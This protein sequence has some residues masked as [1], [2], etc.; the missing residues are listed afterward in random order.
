MLGLVARNCRIAALVRLLQRRSFVLPVP[1]QAILSGAMPSTFCGQKR[2]LLPADHILPDHY[3]QVRRSLLQQRSL[4]HKKRRS[5]IGPHAGLFFENFDTMYIQ[6]HEMVLI[7]KG[8]E[9][10]FAD[11]CEAY[12]NLVPTG[13]DFRA[14][15][16]FEI[17][18]RALRERLL[19]EYVGVEGQ[20]K[21]R[22]AQHTVAAQSLTDGRVLPAGKT[23]AVHFLRF[24]LSDQ[25]AADFKSLSAESPVLFSVEHPS[26]A[27]TVA[28]SAECVKE[29]ASDLD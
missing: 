10:Q 28:L 25:Q 4:I 7:E 12:Q 5:F 15:F 3:N 9:R 6:A 20:M 17:D 23:T 14:T 21:L 29:L 11:E 18:N 13:R 27:H 16:M 24:P 22:F 8:G 1:S 2:Q 19:R 26:Y